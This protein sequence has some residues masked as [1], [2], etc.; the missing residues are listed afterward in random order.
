MELRRATMY[1]PGPGDILECDS[2]GGGGYGDPYERPVELVLA[3]VVDELLSVEKAREAY[4][5]IIDPQTL[6]VDQQGTRALREARRVS[7]HRN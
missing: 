2:S 5:V 7:P 4:G 6:T 3:N 1:R